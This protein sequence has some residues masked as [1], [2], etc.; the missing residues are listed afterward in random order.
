[1][2]GQIVIDRETDTMYRHTYG[3]TDTR[4]PIQK[5]RMTDGQTDRC[6]SRQIDGETDRQADR[7]TKE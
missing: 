4:T 7:H 6:T 2:D 1:M 3:Q 5:S